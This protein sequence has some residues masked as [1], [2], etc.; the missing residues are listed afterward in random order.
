MVLLHAHAGP[1]KVNLSPTDERT[2]ARLLNHLDLLPGDQ[3][4]GYMF[5][6]VAAAAGWFTFAGSLVPLARLKTVTCPVRIWTLD[7]EARPN[8]ASEHGG[9]GCRD[10][11]HW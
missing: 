6:G 9:P 2:C 3:A 8:S 4:Q 7:P 5:L 11:E 1:G 10:H